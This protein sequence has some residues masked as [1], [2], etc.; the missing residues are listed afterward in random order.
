VSK[1]RWTTLAVVVA[2]ASIFS[3]EWA[4]AP[5][6]H[7]SAAVVKQLTAVHGELYLGRSFEGLPLRTVRPFLYSDC[8]PG[9]P[10][11]IPCTWVR[12][13]RGRV[14][15]RDPAQVERAITKL[16]RVA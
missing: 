8:L 14:T 3:W 15:G 10:H 2:C 9:K 5:R 11:I 13:D 16:R 4:A 12:V 1:R 7:A 6:V